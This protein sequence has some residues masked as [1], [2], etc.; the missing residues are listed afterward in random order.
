MISASIFFDIVLF[1]LLIL[2]NGASFMSISSLVHWFWNYDNFFLWPEIQISEIPPSEICPISGDWAKLWI[3]N[4]TWVSL[5]EFNWMLQNPRATSFTVFEL[6]RE[7]Q[8]EGG[9]GGVKLLSPFPNQIRF[10]GQS[11]LI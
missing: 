4:L 10:K 11:S 5:I 9:G 2:V 3:P 6:W 8:L 7:I 1:L